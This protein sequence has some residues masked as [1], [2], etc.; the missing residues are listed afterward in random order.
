MAAF[1]VP[2]D[3]TNTSTTTAGA[4][5]C[6]ATLPTVTTPVARLLGWGEESSGDCNWAKEED[7]DQVDASLT[8]KNF[9]ADFDDQDDSEETE[10]EDDTQGDWDEGTYSD[11]DGK[12]EDAEADDEAGWDYQVAPELT[13]QEIETDFD[14]QADSGE[15]EEEDGKQACWDGWNNSDLG[16]VTRDAEVTSNPGWDCHCAEGPKIEESDEGY[17]SETPSPEEIT[18]QNIPFRTK[19]YFLTYVQRI[20]EAA[21]LDY[22]RTHLSKYLSDRD[23]KL[24]RFYMG[25]KQFELGSLVFR[26][27]LAEDHIELERWMDIFE[28]FAAK[29]DKPPRAPIH[30]CVRDLRNKAVHREGEEMYLE[31][32][33]WAMQLPTL[34]DDTKREIELTNAF[35]FVMG[36]PT[37]DQD[38]KTAVETAIFTPPACTSPHKLLGRIQTLLEE[39]CFNHASE[40]MPEELAAKGITMPEQIELQR[41]ENLFYDND[42][43]HVDSANALFSDLISTSLTNHLSSAR[44]KIRNRVAHYSLLDDEALSDSVELG[45]KICLFMGDRRQVIEI[46]SLTATYFAN[47]PRD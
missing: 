8:R 28:F 17:T 34:L 29:S 41:W 23:W 21:C 16:T 20:L 3:A 5:T 40:H 32:L 38:T 35:K 6:I 19:H 1:T 4:T 10:R 14:N 44:T 9:M 11:F 42:V 7:S 13:K 22:A 31:V 12:S 2:I 18:F 37:L 30:Y 43:H 46:E 36:D 39:T 26:D 33:T 47:R 27:C 24:V 15:V 45:I 25:N